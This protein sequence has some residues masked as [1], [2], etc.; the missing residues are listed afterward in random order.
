VE[1][2]VSI[3][4]Y[5]EL[6]AFGLGVKYNEKIKVQVPLLFKERTNGCIVGIY[7]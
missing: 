1:L 6:S 3:D 2:P 4:F 7:F 5:K